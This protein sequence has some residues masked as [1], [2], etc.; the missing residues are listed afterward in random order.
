MNRRALARLALAVT[1][2]SLAACGDNGGNDYFVTPEFP[3]G[4]HGA[5]KNPHTGVEFRGRKSTLYEGGLRTN[6]FI[7]PGP[8]GQCV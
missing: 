6:A 8:G 2:A 5:N 1:L 7:A 4:V 3:R